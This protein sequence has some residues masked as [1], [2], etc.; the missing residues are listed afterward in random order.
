LVIDAEGAG[1]RNLVS[2]APPEHAAG[3]SLSTRK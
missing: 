3:S 1:Y 2:R